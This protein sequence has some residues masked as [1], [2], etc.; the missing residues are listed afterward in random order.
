MVI[1]ADSP[2]VSNTLPLKALSLRNAE[3][4]TQD[5]TSNTYIYTSPSGISSSES[6]LVNTPT[7]ALSPLKLQQENDEGGPVQDQS[8]KE[9]KVASPGGSN[10]VE[11]LGTIRSSPTSPS[12]R[13]EQEDLLRTE[14]AAHQETRNKLARLEAL[15]MD[16]YSRLQDAGRLISPHDKVWAEYRDLMNAAAQHISTSPNARDENMDS[17]DAS[18]FEELGEV[19]DGDGRETDQND[20]EAPTFNTD[21]MGDHT[22]TN[23]VDAI[24]AEG[25]GT[26]SDNDDDHDDEISRH[27]RPMRPGTAS[28]LPMSFFRAQSQE[29]FRQPSSSHLGGPQESQEAREPVVPAPSSSLPYPEVPVELEEE[30]ESSN[31]FKFTFGRNHTVF[32]KVP[33]A[34][35]A[36]LSR[37]TGEVEGIEESVPQ[38][39]ASQP[40]FSISFDFGNAGETSRSEA[41]RRTNSRNDGR[42]SQ[43]SSRNKSRLPRMSELAYDPAIFDFSRRSQPE[44]SVRSSSSYVTENGDSGPLEAGNE[45]GSQTIGASDANVDATAAMIDPFLEAQHDLLMQSTN[46]VA[47]LREA[48]DGKTRMTDG[49]P[50]DAPSE[51]ITRA[52]R[53]TWAPFPW[54]EV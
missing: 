22:L 6:T 35:E 29:R 34:E 25:Y 49:E 53:A 1:Q 16:F 19:E 11:S 39:E 32:P 5:V 18:R 4:R 15:G 45:P 14:E 37:A 3:A 50:E 24:Q 38:P 48:R 9:A 54:V 26:T 41:S 10:S 40:I 30:L 42:G 27:D 51:N 12:G 23:E 21:M 44:E 8:S 33:T 7:E 47:E 17:H 2:N 46:T 13:W 43:N 28:R 36:D 20:S 52:T 31:G